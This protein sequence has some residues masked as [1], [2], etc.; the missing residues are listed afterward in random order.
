MSANEN[1]DDYM[2]LPAGESHNCFGCPKNEAGLQ[3]EFYLNEKLDTVVS[4]LSV[5]DHL[6]GW[7]NIV[8]GGIIST[9]LDEAM[10]WAGLVLF[11]SSY[12]Q[13]PYQSSFS[14]PCSSTER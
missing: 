12:S 2:L 8:H 11:V 7:G 5:P 6:C 1:R 9:L 3:M 10:G 4:W 13:N 14:S